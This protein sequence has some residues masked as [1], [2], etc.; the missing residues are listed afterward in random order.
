M[1]FSVSCIFGS[2]PNSVVLWTCQYHCMKD[3]VS[4][5]LATSTLLGGRGRGLELNRWSKEVIKCEYHNK[6]TKTRDCFIF[7]NFILSLIVRQLQLL[8]YCKDSY[9]QHFKPKYIFYI[10]KLKIIILSLYEL[11]TYFQMN[12]RRVSS[13]AYSICVI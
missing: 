4:Q 2:T 7:T 9:W 5:N 6:N 12:L 8:C 3:W 10:F 13:G 1:F 11:L